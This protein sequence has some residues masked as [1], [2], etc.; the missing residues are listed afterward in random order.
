MFRIKNKNEK[1]DYIPKHAKN[2]NI[3]YVNLNDSDDNALNY[4]NRL[5]VY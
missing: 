2:S 3:R 4:S 5:N 1:I